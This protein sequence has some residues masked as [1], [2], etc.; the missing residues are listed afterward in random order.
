MSA[1]AVVVG[2]VGISVAKG[3]EQPAP[4]VAHH[5]EQ[6][7]AVEGFGEE[8]LEFWKGVVLEEVAGEFSSQ[9]SRLRFSPSR[10]LG[11]PDPRVYAAQGPARLG[12]W[13]FGGCAGRRAC[14]GD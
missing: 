9:E 13:R 4:G 2:Q 11:S 7:G 1:V 8:L 14:A 12:C 5:G 6:F 3:G 10:W